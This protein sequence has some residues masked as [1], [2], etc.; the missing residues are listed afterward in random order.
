MLASLRIV[1]AG[2][3]RLN[4]EV[5]EAFQ[6]KFNKPIFEGYGA[7]ETTPVASVNLPDALDHHYWQV[8]QGNKIGTVGMPLPGTSFKI[9]DPET[10]EVTYKVF[11][12]S[13]EES[14]NLTEN[15]VKPTFLENVLEDLKEEIP[16]I[17]DVNIDPNDKIDVEIDFVVDTTNTDFFNISQTCILHRILKN[18]SF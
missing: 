15:L 17:T 5:S 10:N 1:V 11:G 8:Q 12:E 4:P 9:V 16:E 2:A 3:E 6:L 7:T 13:A 14:A 18:R